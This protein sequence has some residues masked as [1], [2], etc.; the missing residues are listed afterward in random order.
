LN[1]GQLVADILDMQRMAGGKLRLNLRGLDLGPVIQRAIDTVTPAA[2]AKQ[3]EIHAVLDPEAG[4]V[5]GDEDRL[6]QVMWNLLS[7]AVKFTPKGGRVQVGLVRVDSHV[8]ITVED[9][10]PGLEPG[11]IPYAFD[12]FRQA[13]SSSTRRHGGL[14]LG[15]AIVRNLVELHGGSVAADNRTVG[16]G[17]LFVV[18]LPRMSVRPALHA[19]SAEGRHP[20]VDQHVSMDAAPSLHG[21]RVLVV[22]DEFDSRELIAAALGRCGA[23]V[24]SAASSEEALAHL[25]G[26]RHDVLVSDIEMP[27]EDGYAFLEKVRRLPPDE[28]GLTPAVALTAYA[29]TEDR[30][31]AL[32][33][34]F[35]IH[36]PKPVQPAELALVVSSLARGRAFR[37]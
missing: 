13:D 28:G 34:G 8:E 29:G 19:I 33:A 37:A 25:K 30:M 31:H 5:L 10:G 2:E 35:Q 24:V 6:Q 4:P 32:A 36:V 1:Q 16:T 12:R 21:I 22:D 23:E 14:G 15:L 17:A 9:S 7:N 26:Q 20:A 11:F 27:G 3:I 18:R